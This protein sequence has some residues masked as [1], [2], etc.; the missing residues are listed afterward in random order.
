MQVV[1]ERVTLGRIGKAHGISG[2]FRL[3][4][5]ADNLER[6][7]QL[8]SVTLV[9]GKRA[10][11]ATVQSTR[12]AGRHVIVQTDA[13][14][15]PEDVRP[16]LGGDLEIDASERVAPEPGRFYYEDVIGLA[17]ETTDGRVVGKITDIIEAPASDIYVCRDGEKEFMIPAVDAFVKEYDITG[18][19]LVVDPIPGLLE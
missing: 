4:P 17:V 6:F 18:G 7:A 16:W 19:R 8:R 3:W 14:S 1:T 5:Y 9:H 2:A 12:I 13:L 15:T 10:L 11:P